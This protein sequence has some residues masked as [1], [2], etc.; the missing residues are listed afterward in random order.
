MNFNQNRLD[1]SREDGKQ[2]LKPQ[3]LELFT[4]R[5]IM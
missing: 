1:Q 3:L 2:Q 5:I 4:V